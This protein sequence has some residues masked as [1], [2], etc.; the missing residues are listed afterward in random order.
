MDWTA[1][2]TKNQNQILKIF[3]IALQYN[4]QQK[5]QSM[6]YI[7]NENHDSETKK[8]QKNPQKIH[9][10]NNKKSYIKTSEQ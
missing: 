3:K 6:R 2:K 1:T 5:Y 8:K 4:T 9:P 7:V 10:H